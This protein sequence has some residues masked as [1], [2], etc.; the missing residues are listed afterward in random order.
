MRKLIV[1]TRGEKGSLAINGD[2]IVECA[3][4]KSSSSR[5]NRCRRFICWRISSWIYKWE[6]IEELKIG[7]GNIFKSYSII[8]ARIN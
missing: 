3:A 5:F 4:Q 7:T 6:S 2:E 1:V 8:G